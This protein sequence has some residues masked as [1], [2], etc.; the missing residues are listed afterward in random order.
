MMLTPKFRRPAV[1][2]AALRLLI[3][4]PILLGVMP[5]TLQAQEQAS[6]QDFGILKSAELAAALQKKDFLLINVHVPY[7][8]EIADTDAFIPFD[9]IADNLDKLPKDK[10][11]K[12]V[13]YCRSGRMS[14]I[15]ARALAQ[16][17]YARISHLAG[18]M[19]DWKQ[20]G[21]QIIEKQP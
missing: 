14:E 20:S 3:C 1:L 6:T 18:G 2:G 7:E 5:G 19:I 4:T 8:G 9:K 12:I 17:G 13:L 21:Y 10:S 16:L 15:A 11:A